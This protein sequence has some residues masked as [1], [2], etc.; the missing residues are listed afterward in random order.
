MKDETTRVDGPGNGF[1]V[2]ASV[3]LILFILYVLSPGPVMS[4][5]KRGFIPERIGYGAVMAFYV[6]TL[7]FPLFMITLVL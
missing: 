2:L 5:G 7:L 1:S 4:L 3:L 6:L